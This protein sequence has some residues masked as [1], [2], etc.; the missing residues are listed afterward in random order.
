MKRMRVVMITG[1]CVLA[2]GLS[3]GVGN[4]A[5]AAW[6]GFEVSRSALIGNTP[7]RKV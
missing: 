1:L 6:S 3:F 5:A 7:A 2:T 4:G